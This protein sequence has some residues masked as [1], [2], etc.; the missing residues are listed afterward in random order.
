MLSLAMLVPLVS[1]CESSTKTGQ[2]PTEFESDYLEFRNRLFER[3]QPMI[4]KIDLVENRPCLRLFS[5][6]RSFG[7]RRSF[8]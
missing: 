4:E 5:N 8:S 6:Q 7:T 3:Y 2:E 1:F